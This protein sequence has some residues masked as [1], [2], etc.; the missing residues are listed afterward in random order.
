MNRV[1]KE[2]EKEIERREGDRRTRDRNEGK[3][4]HVLLKVLSFW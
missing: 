1:V 3:K 4:V 2:K